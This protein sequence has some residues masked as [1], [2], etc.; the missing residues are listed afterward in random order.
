[1]GMGHSVRHVLAALA[2]AGVLAFFC[3]LLV[4]A[5]VIQ[6]EGYYETSL[7]SKAKVERVPAARGKILDR[8]GKVLVRDEVRWTAV[9]AEG[10]PEESR[11]R[12]AQLCREEGV[13]WDGEGAVT[14]V[15]A[16]LLARGKEEGLEGVTFSPAVERVG[17]GALAPHVLGRVGAMSPEQWEELKRKGYA[18]EETVGKDGAEA[19]FE[20]ALHGTPGRRYVETA[21]S[22]WDTEPVAGKNVTLTLD[23]D[24]QAAAQDALQAFLD[25]HPNASGGAVVALDVEDGGV[26]AM[27]SLP[28][29]DPETFSKQYGA[30]A[31]DE[32]H[33]LM[34]RAI[35]GLYAPGSAF[36]L[37]TATAALEEGVL[38][39][40]TKILDTGRYTYYKNPQPQC[41]L[42]RQAGK[43]HG[44]ETVTDAI[45]DSCNIFFF[46]A[47]RRVGIE[48]LGT[49]AKALGLGEKTGIELAGE[50]AGVV[51]GPAY[52]ASVGGTWYEGSVLSAA[53]GQENHR[54]TPVQLAHMTATLVSGGERRQVHLLK[55]VA[56]E[57]AQEAVSLGKIALSEKNLTAIKEGMRRVVQSG[58]L[59][60][61]FR[62]LPVT[63]GAKTGSAQVAGEEESNAVLVCFAPYDAPKIALALVAE[64]GGSGAALGDAAAAILNTWAAGNLS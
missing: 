8:N 42:Y 10:A 23:K 6:G 55:Q 40:E 46:D 24:L 34:N 29:Y 25:G 20:E 14:G 50:Q 37:V 61:A 35:Q 21:G 51:A 30:L 41:W 63:A 27:V 4:R 31:Q 45:A 38:T 58:S 44:L 57:E 36:K 43:T 64:Q 62:D 53:I 11:V 15:I 18:M 48:T 28:G 32:G 17:S 39:P 26:L 9:V 19:A 1:M 7:R 56:G 12:L 54:F 5:Q 3:V 60:E 16:R 13:R 47:G 2:F 22:G 33:P 59:A 52:T 49:Y